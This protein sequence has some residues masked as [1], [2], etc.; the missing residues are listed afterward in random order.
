VVKIG[1]IVEGETEKL[2]ID[3]ANFQSLLLNLNLECVSEAID[4]EGNGNLLPH[5][6][7]PFRQI[8]QDQL[9]EWIIILTDLDTSVSIAETKERIT[10]RDK[11]TIV[12]AVKMVEAWFLADNELMSQLLKESYFHESPQTEAVPFNT[13]GQLVFEKTGRGI[14]T[15]KPKFA[16]KVLS[17][18][19]SIERAAQ[20]PNCP[21]AAYLVQTLKQ[22]S[23]QS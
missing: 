6:I 18:G 8:L 7:V 21:S 1:F 14:G 3:S 15:R 16:R 4:A 20:H 22:I 13:I 11:Q 2:L 10:E 5:N 19:F 12:V 23:T 9:A 17:M